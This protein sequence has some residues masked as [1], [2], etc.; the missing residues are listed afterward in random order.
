MKFDKRFPEC[1]GNT[2]IY[3]IEKNLAEVR[4]RMLERKRLDTKIR[5]QKKQ[6]QKKEFLTKF[7]PIYFCETCNK[8]KPKQ[9]TILTGKLAFSR[10][11]PCGKLLTEQYKKDWNSANKLKISERAH[12]LYLENREHLIKVNNIRKNKWRKENPE[13][14]KLQVKDYYNRNKEKL[15]ANGRRWNKE[16][17]ALKASLTAKRRALKKQATPKWLTKEHFSEMRS[18]YEQSRQLKL[19]TGIIYEVDHIC[20]LQSDVVCGLH[21]PWNLRVIPKVENNAKLNKVIQEL[22]CQ[23]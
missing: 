22:I 9:D 15:N 21:V 11:K 16:K 3:C 17:S 20:P 1:I 18:F 19:E 6:Q 7:T 10:C 8:Y 2:C 13:L 14:Y 12:E 23:I 5:H 4:E